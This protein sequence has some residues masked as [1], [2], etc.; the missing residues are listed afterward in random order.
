[1]QISGSVV[2]SRLAAAEE[3]L[4]QQ[5]DAALN[6]RSDAEQAIH[7]FSQQRAEAVLEL[8]DELLSEEAAEASRNEHAELSRRLDD[9]LRKREEKRTDIQ[10]QIAEIKKELAVRT[11]RFEEASNEYAELA[12]RTQQLQQVT[13]TA[14]Q[15]DA[16]FVERSQE[17]AATQQALALNEKRINELTRQAEEKLPAYRESRL[18][19]YLKRRQ[20]GEANY[21]ASFMTKPLDGWVARLIDYPKL[22]EAFEFLQTA[23]VRM[24]Q[25]VQK[26]R[27]EFERAL[28]KIQAMESQ[29]A[30]RTG[31]N[32]ANQKS[33]SAAQRRQ[34]VNDS[35]METQRRLSDCHSK[36]Q[37]LEGFDGPAFAGA[38]AEFGRWLSSLRTAALAEIAE[39]TPEEEDDRLIAEIQW[40]DE[41]LSEAESELQ[42]FD[43]QQ[44]AAQDQLAGLQWIM[45]QFRARRY[46]SD[47]SAFA[48]DLD[49]ETLLQ[50]YQAGKSIKE[51]FLAGLESK[52]REKQPW[53]SQAW[54]Q[55]GSIAGHP[56]TQTLLIAVANIAGQAA[57][58]A[59]GQR[60]FDQKSA[61]RRRRR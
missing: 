9:L 51:S 8:A 28:E 48:A 31:L 19:Q 14:L 49:I 32:Q 55:I 38:T 20:Y 26:R 11:R 57:A 17:A 42:R 18:F 3:E 56:A 24:R 37:Q 6:A 50:R 35:L 45:G 58:A 41:R 44:L 52:Q 15:N 4:R 60:I 25:E 34:E 27:S 39:R 40:C 61:G 2:Y 53:G 30:L 7:K 1:M 46:D 23:P 22:A 5:V 29:A 47:Q 54:S 12:Q 16:T 10:A 13:T 21:S 43:Q 36:L 59:I 33:R